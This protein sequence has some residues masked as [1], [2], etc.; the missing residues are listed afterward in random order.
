M[1]SPMLAMVGAS[2][3]TARQQ[4]GS[5]GHCMPRRWALA[6]SGGSMGMIDVCGDEVSRHVVCLGLPCKVKTQFEL[7]ASYS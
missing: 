6:A 2:I 1:C 7:S 3:V 5:V 4:P